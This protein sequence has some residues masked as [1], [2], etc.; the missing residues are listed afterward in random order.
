MSLNA[1]HQ[2]AEVRDAFETFLDRGAR[3]RDWHGWSSLFTDD[4]VYTEHCLGQFHG[5]TG[6]ESWI[7]AA[8]QPVACM[9]FSLEWTVIE[10][11]YVTFW[12]WNHLPSPPGS[13]REFCFPNFSI[14]VYNGDGKWS[15]EEDFY[16]PAW[17][18]CVIDWYRAGGSPSQPA[19]P[20]LVP[21]RPSHPTPPSI[22]PERHVVMGALADACP[23]GTAFRHDV[24]GG[25]VGIG[26]YD[27]DERAYAVI[28]HVDASGQT[29]FS[30]TVTNPNETTNPAR[31]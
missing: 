31:R 11:N 22:A 30:Q 24:V 10:G 2:Q 9:T 14:L 21:S 19:N 7:T 12:I 26:I 5:A 8:M 16:D 27:T 25:S 1:S 29:V 20:A 3:G 4:A 13:D 28:V 18:G 6:I 15:A 17:A 23:P